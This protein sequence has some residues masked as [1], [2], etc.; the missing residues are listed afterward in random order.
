MSTRV[1]HDSL[2]EVA[3]PADALYGAQTQR[4]IDN[5]QLSGIP[6]PRPFLRG[7]GLVKACCAR[8]NQELGLL[9]AAL[10]AAIFNAAM[11]VARGELEVEAGLREG[12]QVEPAGEADGAAAALRGERVDRRRVAGDA[13]PARDVA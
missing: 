8:V 7:L 4:A 1:E 12:G 9:N 5:F 10:A 11:R 2:G 6:M 13:D 3:V